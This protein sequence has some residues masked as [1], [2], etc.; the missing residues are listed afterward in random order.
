MTALL[1]LP[2]RSA[3]ATVVIDTVKEVLAQRG[4]PDAVV[5]M[6]TRLLGARAVFDS[7]GLVTVIVDLEQRIEDAFGHALILASERAMSQ[8]NS[9]FLSIESL[10]DYV[11]GQMT[12][13]PDAGA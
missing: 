5:D 2:N 9:P 4:R 8:A 11:Y 13:G 3:V 10:T 6:G 7:L 1:P 12:G